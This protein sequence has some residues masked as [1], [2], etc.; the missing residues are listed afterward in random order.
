MQR[1]RKKTTSDSKNEG[2]IEQVLQRL[3]PDIERIGPRLNRILND[4]D[5]ATP[6]TTM[7]KAQGLLTSYLKMDTI[8]ARFLM[9][10]LR[11]GLKSGVHEDFVRAQLDDVIKKAKTE[12]SRDPRY[13]LLLK[14]MHEVDQVAPC[15]SYIV[16]QRHADPEQSFL[17]QMDPLAD[18]EAAR[19]C[20]GER[21]FNHSIE[22]LR[23]TVEHL[24]DPYIKT[25][26]YLTYVRDQKDSDDFHNI[27]VIKFGVA[28]NHLNS[29]LADH[30]GLFDV[31][32]AFFRNAVT[33]DIPQYDFATDSVVLNDNSRS[34]RISTDDLL[35][36]AE[37]FYQL[38][39][40]TVVFVSQLYL[41]REIFRNTGF[42][43]LCMEYLPLMALESDPSKLQPIE[44]EFQLRI[45]KAFGLKK[46]A[47]MQEC[48]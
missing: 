35:A 44:H 32:A 14:F 27:S 48:G 12:A 7:A 16:V 29:R 25:L 23:R 40:K 24:Y 47:S 43:D 37:S 8:R 28:L 38:S 3:F 2:R 22:A 45:E 26:V 41:F 9:R 39:A 34:V 30:P 46:I 19:N 6:R 1:S 18:L 21:R 42:F 20:S 15:G 17:K 5:P 13:A 10:I 33:H 31:R 4:F 36:M 11:V